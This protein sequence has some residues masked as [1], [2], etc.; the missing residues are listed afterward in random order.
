M[1][2]AG[3]KLHRNVKLLVQH[4]ADVNWRGPIHTPLMTAIRNAPDLEDFLLRPNSPVGG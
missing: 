1:L 2:A 4:G 3:M